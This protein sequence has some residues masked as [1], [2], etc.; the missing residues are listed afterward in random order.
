MAPTLQRERARRFRATAAAAALVV[1]MVPFADAQ[2]I[3]PS[4]VPMVLPSVLEPNIVLTLEDSTNMRRAFA[5]D[6]MFSVAPTGNVEPAN[7]RR[8]KSSTFNPLYYDPRVTYVIPANAHSGVLGS[9][10]QA[11]VANAFANAYINGFYETNNNATVNLGTEYRPTLIF[12]PSQASNGSNQSFAS[13]ASADLVDGRLGAVA[14]TA[15]VAAYYYVYDPSDPTPIAGQSC[16]NSIDTDACYRLIRVTATS[17]PGATDERLN[18][19][20]WYSFYRTRHLAMVSAAARVFDDQSLVGTRVAWQ[21][22]NSCTTLLRTSGA[23]NCD[24][25]TVSGGSNSDRENRLRRFDT[26]AQADLMSWLRRVPASNN[27]VPLRA[28]TA[29]VGDYFRRSDTSSS[30]PN[31]PYLEVPLAAWNATT[32]REYACRPNFHI[33]MAGSAWDDTGIQYCNG[34]A[35]GDKDGSTQSF[36]ITTVNG[37]T[38]Y[39]PAAP[40]SDGTPANSNSLADIAFHYWVTDLRPDAAMP[41]DKLLPYYV[42]RMGTL[43]Q[44]DMNPKNDPARWQHLVNYVVGVGLGRALGYNGPN[45][46][47]PVNWGDTGQ[48]TG[49]LFDLWHA[50]VNSRGGFFGADTPGQIVDALTASLR[51]AAPVNR[52]PDGTINFSVGAALATNSTRLTTESALYQ[53]QFRVD[54]WTGRLARIPVDSTGAL[55]CTLD[56]SPACVEAS[57][58]I[59]AHGARNVVTSR[60]AVRAGVAFDQVGLTA[61]GAWDRFGADDTARANVVNFL[62]GDQTNEGTN[63]G[64]FRVRSARLG[65]IVNSDIVFAGKESF[66][67]QNL[68]P[69]NF[70]SGVNTNSY[71]DFVQA[72]QSRK[73][74]IYVGAN[75]GMIHGFDAET[76][77]EQ[78]AYVP[79]A[80]LLETVSNLDQRPSIARLS[81]QTYKDAHRYF[82]DG[83]PWVGDACLKSPASDCSVTDWRTVLVG[84]TGAGGKGVFAL[85]VTRPDAFSASDVL[86]DL[87]GAADIDMGYPM[88]QPVIG[89]LHDNNY[90]AIYG[91][92]YS[93]ERG[94]PV[95]YLV[96]LAT[97]DIRRL[98]AAEGNLG[99]NN[100]AAEC[101]GARTGLGRPSLFDADSDRVTDAIYVGDTLGRLWKF[102]VSSSDSAQWG[103]F[104][105]SGNSPVPLFTARNKCGGVQS[106]TGLIEIGAAPSGQSGAMLYFG[107]GRF[108]SQADKAD[109]TRQTFYGILDRGSSTAALNSP[110]TATAGETPCTSPP[111]TDSSGGSGDKSDRGKLQEQILGALDAN[112]RREITTNAT[113]NYSSNQKNLGWYIDL[114]IAGERMVTAPTLLGGRV[115]FPTLVPTAD[116]CDGGG[117]SMIVAVDPFSGKKTVRNIFDYNS[118]GTITYDS[119]KLA[120]G[121]VKNVVAIDAGSRVYL[122]AGGSTSNVEVIQTRAV[123]QTGGAV[124]GR[125]SW[126]EVVK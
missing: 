29:R 107:T 69:D 21:A 49:K 124:R 116:A 125:V 15:G 96:N 46:P 24:G 47:P 1:V 41:N 10:T 92:G 4:Q 2:D 25:Y 117:F 110:G 95:L 109:E 100:S 62:R 50:A 126:R 60:G 51:R 71:A 98:S 80:L 118:T 40:F 38:S 72:K 11:N 23:S 59:P 93:S 70:S 73:K 65:D 106:I 105:R 104:N 8:F 7:T 57:S 55:Q 35:C 88:G 34:A 3:V 28:A 91:N 6:S 17:G 26:T 112:N 99:S 64:Q 97:G 76:M 9:Y 77:V 102:D 101:T 5:P 42:D 86:W 36:P 43:T 67:Y 30:V 82:V 20:T 22:V 122:F 37:T 78:F 113:V 90:Y 75:D 123:E 45:T 27:N 120:V 68:S 61:V 63:P 84:T 56:G 66:G 14:A 115:V 89:R 44:Q 121:V 85:D 53:A 81:D 108:L 119:Y 33:L 94:C 52:N 12:D 74:M 54:D 58:L 114:P 16:N 83:S 48:A 103:V 32:N 31:N 79:R 39:T 18:F 13:H 19:L 87:N 111:A